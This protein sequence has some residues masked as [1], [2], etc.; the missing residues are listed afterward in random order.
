MQSIR[1]VTLCIAAAVAY[2][3]IQDQITARISVEYF[4][5]GH[6]QLIHSESPT[7]LGLLWGVLGTWWAGGALGVLLATAARA[8]RRPKLEAGELMLPVL[9]VMLLSGAVASIAGIIGYVIASAGW[10][11]LVGAFATRMPSNRHVAFISV[12]W[13]HTAAYLSAAAFSVRLALRL[14]QERKGLE[15][16]PAA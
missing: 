15:S 16:E 13:I 2:G 5:I 7:H 4:T 14:T 9:R 8:G 12:G 3:V 10:V 11:H 6:V 1:I